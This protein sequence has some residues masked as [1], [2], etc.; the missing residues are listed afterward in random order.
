MEVPVC[1]AL[2]AIRAWRAINHRLGQHAALVAVEQGTSRDNL[3]PRRS[4]M[5]WGTVPAPPGVFLPVSL[6]RNCPVSRV[7][8][9][10]P[11][12]VFYR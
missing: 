3:S 11:L 12:S 7:S 8:R 6:N 9:L 5:F 4:S 10:A 1:R 2:P